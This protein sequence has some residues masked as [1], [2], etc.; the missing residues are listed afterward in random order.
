MEELCK[1][2]GLHISRAPNPV[3]EAT[4]TDSSRINSVRG[5]EMIFPIEATEN[6]IG[7][8]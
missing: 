6:A 3:E 1:A 2:Q 8:N 4:L 7:K 5:Q